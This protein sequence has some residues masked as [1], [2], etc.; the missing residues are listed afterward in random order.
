M[1]PSTGT[2]GRYFCV[3]CFNPI[4]FRLIPNRSRIMAARLP[5]ARLSAQRLTTLARVTRGPNR[6]RGVQGLSTLTRSNASP[7][8]SGLLRVSSGYEI[9]LYGLWF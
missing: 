6:L 5:F 7:K 4:S 1:P 2:P 9:A 8:A 3:L